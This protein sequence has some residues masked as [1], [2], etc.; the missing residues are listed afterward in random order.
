MVGAG[1]QETKLETVVHGGVSRNRRNF[2]H[3]S[4]NPA[5]SASR[6]MSLP[7]LWKVY[8]PAYP[9]GQVIPDSRYEA[10]APFRKQA[11]SYAAATAGFCWPDAL[12]AVRAHP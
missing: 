3:P 9:S 8:V 12:A 11:T 1:S 2:R 10:Y 6:S 4:S 7:L 5:T